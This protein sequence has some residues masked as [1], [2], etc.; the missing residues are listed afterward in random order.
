MHT[1]SQQPPTQD[2]NYVSQKDALIFLVDCSASMTQLPKASAASPLSHFQEVIRVVTQM[3]K[4]KI[5]SGDSAKVALVFYNT[6]GCSD[7]RVA[8]LCVS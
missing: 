7:L 1:D 2:K 8:V 6:V 3:M 4:T 5:I